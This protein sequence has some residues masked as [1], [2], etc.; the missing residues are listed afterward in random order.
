MYTR[1]GCRLV[2]AAEKYARVRRRTCPLNNIIPDVCV[3][4]LVSFLILI[5][6]RSDYPTSAERAKPRREHITCG[7]TGSSGRSCAL[8]SGGLF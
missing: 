7:P 5:R 3:R 6:E 2:E 8:I 1:A 4:V